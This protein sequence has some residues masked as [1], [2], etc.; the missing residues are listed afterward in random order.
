MRLDFYTNVSIASCVFRD[1]QAP[2]AAD[3]QVYGSGGAISSLGVLDI[4]N[5][6]FEQNSASNSGGAIFMN[7]NLSLAT[8]EDST[9]DGNQAVM[10]GGAILL[11]GVLNVD[12]S[13][14]FNNSARNAAGNS[15]SG[16]AICVQSSSFDKLTLTNS[17]ISGNTAVFGGGI[18]NF[19]N[20][21]IQAS[22]IA[23]NHAQLRRRH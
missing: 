17:T 12:R 7:S 23:N 1:N 20:A 3:N 11:Q 19:M 8:I 10:D 2:V 9:F 18:S 5:S 22:T 6:R 15:G 14:F 13:A 16:G 4:R 21:V